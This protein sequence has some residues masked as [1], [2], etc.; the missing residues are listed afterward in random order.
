[1][2][3]AL[4]A[5]RLQS[6]T[7]GRLGVVAVLLVAVFVLFFPARQI[8]QQRG[9]MEGLEAR[10]AALAAENERL[11]EEVAR[12]ENPEELEALARERL[13]LVKPGEDAYY[14]VEPSSPE[15]DEAPAEEPP[16]LS[17]AWSWLTELIRGG[18]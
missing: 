14:F 9:D 17:R 5:R 16:P 12:L 1:M 2:S 10:L 13:G 4:A 6:L 11:A 18:G 3:T 7:Q 8:V 15:A